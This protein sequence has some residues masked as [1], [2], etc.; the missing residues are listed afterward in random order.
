MNLCILCMCVYLQRSEESIRLLE[1]EPG[2]LKEQSELFTV[3][4]S[5]VPCDSV[6]WEVISAP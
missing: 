5:S 6:Y 3:E 2:P 1:N 4:L